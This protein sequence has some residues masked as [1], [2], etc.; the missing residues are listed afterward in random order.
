MRDLPALSHRSPRVPSMQFLCAGM[1]AELQRHTAPPRL[2]C[3]RCVAGTRFRLK[4]PCTARCALPTAQVSLAPLAPVRGLCDLDRVCVVARLWRLRLQRRRRQEIAAPRRVVLPASAH[5]LARKSHRPL[6]HVFSKAG[7]MAHRVSRAHQTD[8]GRTASRPARLQSRQPSVTA[9]C[10]SRLAPTCDERARRLPEQRL[11][12]F[13]K[14]FASSRRRP[15]LLA[16]SSLRLSGIDLRSC[17][18]SAATASTRSPYDFMAAWCDWVELDIGIL[19]GRT[20]A[21]ACFDCCILATA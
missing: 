8:A 1:A 12:R 11:A 20:P 6:L 21:R 17:V 5:R 2:R 15:D 13:C 18:S 7:G 16:R 4:A 19:V 14:C 9:R 3:A 10:E